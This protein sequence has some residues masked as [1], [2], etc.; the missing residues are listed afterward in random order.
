MI[1]HV[2]MVTSLVSLKG[3][4]CLVNGEGRLMEKIAEVHELWSLMA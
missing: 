4:H 1:F 3:D 2:S